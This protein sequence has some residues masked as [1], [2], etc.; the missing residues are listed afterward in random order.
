MIHTGSTAEFAKANLVKP[1]TVIVSL[2]RHGHYMGVKPVKLANGR[3]IWP[4]APVT[5][6]TEVAQ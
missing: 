3:L 6:K 2:S 4:I 5:A 1:Q